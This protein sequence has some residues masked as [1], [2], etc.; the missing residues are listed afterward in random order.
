MDE[1]TSECAAVGETMLAACYKKPL[2]D[3]EEAASAITAFREWILAGKDRQEQ[4]QGFPD[5][6]TARIYAA[7]MFC[8]EHGDGDD[9]LLCNLSNY[10]CFA[11]DRETF[12]ECRE[13]IDALE[14][15]MMEA[16]EFL[17]QK[18]QPPIEEDDE[19]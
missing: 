10:G 3:A 1:V 8:N 16:E 7:A 18:M 5:P 12:S 14:G 13:A 19:D 11:N 6:F 4:V 17:Q 2:P 15:T 9:D